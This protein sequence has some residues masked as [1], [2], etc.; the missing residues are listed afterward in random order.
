MKARTE[1]PEWVQSLRTFLR[2]QVGSS[3][4]VKEKKGNNTCL[5]I[6]YEDGSRVEKNL[7]IKWNKANSAKIRTRVEEIHNLMQGGVDIDEALERTQTTEARK[8][9]K[10]VNPKTIL[11]AWSKYETYKTKQLGDVDQ[12]NWNKE[13][14]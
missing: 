9:K 1:A 5:R 14:G 8:G 2:D 10:K 7:N 11:S 4:Q 12:D 13:Y 6:R 3:L